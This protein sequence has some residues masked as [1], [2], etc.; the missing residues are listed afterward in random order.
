MKQQGKRTGE[1]AKRSG[2]KDETPRALKKVFLCMF[3]QTVGVRNLV[4]FLLLLFVIQIVAYI[5]F[6]IS[7]KLD[8]FST[9]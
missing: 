7:V 8:Q 3:L 9:L 5:S 6:T 2:E 1:K 4:V